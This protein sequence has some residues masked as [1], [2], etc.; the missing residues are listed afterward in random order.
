MQTVTC[1]GLK[2]NKII[3]K[4]WRI[5]WNNEANT[6]YSNQILVEIYGNY[7]VNA[8]DIVVIKDES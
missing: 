5:T 2:N 1:N 8:S 3:N 7:G 4:E 6:K